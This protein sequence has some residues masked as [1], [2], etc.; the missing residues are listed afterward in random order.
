[1]ALLRSLPKSGRVL[2]GL[3]AVPQPL[4]WPRPVRHDGKNDLIWRDTSYGSVAVWQ[5]GFSGVASLK[6][7]LVRAL[8]VEAA[9]ADIDDSPRR[10]FSDTEIVGH[11]ASSR[12]SHVHDWCTT[13]E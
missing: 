11:D 4:G 13:V 3:P 2:A 6:S 5:F 7:L 10:H 8:K 9:I 12:S 1:M